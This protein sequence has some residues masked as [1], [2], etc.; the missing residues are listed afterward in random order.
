MQ[1]AINAERYR[2]LLN[3]IEQGF[4]IIELMYDTS[5]RATDYRFLEVNPAFE[6]HTGLRA[7]IG[8]A[9]RGRPSTGTRLSARHT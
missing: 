6:R 3:N 8:V 1:N 7:P 5:G 2:H 4:C 9:G